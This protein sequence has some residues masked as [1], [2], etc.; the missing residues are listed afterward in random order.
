MNKSG[1]ILN[2]KIILQSCDDEYTPEKT[3]ICI[4]QFL[5]NNINLFLAPLGSPT[6]RKYLPFVEEK[7]VLVLFPATSALDFRKP[8][9]T[10]IINWRA[11]G[12]DEAQ[13]LVRYFVKLAGKNLK[14]AVLY[15]DDNFGINCLNGAKKALK[16]TG[17]E[18]L[19][20]ISYAAKDTNLSKQINELLKTNFDVLLMFSSP[21]I[22]ITFLRQTGAP[23]L[24]QKKIGSIDDSAS[25]MV[26][27]FVRK[28]NLNFTVTNIVPNPQ[29]SNLQIVK[30]F[31]ALA[32]KKEITIDAFS[33]AGYIDAA[34]ATEL[35]ARAK[36]IN[37][38]DIVAAAENLKNIDYKGL[39]LNFNPENR[40]IIN[41]M[42]LDT[43]KPEWEEFDLAPA[44][45]AAKNEVE[46]TIQKTVNV[47]T[48]LDLSRITKDYNKPV[49]QTM[50]SFFDNFDKQNPDRSIR[51]TVL[52]H[53]YSPAKA[54]ENIESF[55][56][57]FNTDIILNFSGS[58]TFVACID[59]IRQGK[60]AALFPIPGIPSGIP[61]DL[62][63]C[64]AFRP[65]YFDEAY[66]LTRYI[67]KKF[68]ISTPDDIVFLYQDDSF[69][70]AC[71]DGAHK[72]LPKLVSNKSMR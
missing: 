44:K 49:A 52:D 59:F 16:E 6:T 71:I 13:V 14:F 57:I 17:I 65:S 2:K 66:A 9:L 70:K 51:L 21:P 40:S 7:K 55:L 3:T 18:S 11:S 41:T 19:R 64:I 45:P 20:E 48:S 8:E 37:P 22:T 56:N 50:K 28:E 1:G 38:P 47:G 29:T 30:E 34:L 43:G 58:D 5:K 31:K 10:N 54:K 69:G 35:I 36:S 67:C 23:A 53:E 68:N 25:S 39:K 12:Y 33:L 4:N 32:E 60:I 26:Q 63:Y 27:Q 24:A 15:Q 61:S 72:A 42:W 62:K 46:T